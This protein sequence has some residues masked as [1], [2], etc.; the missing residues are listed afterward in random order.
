LW[1][2]TSDE[3]VCASYLRLTDKNLKYIVIDPNIATVVMGQG[4]SSLFHR[5]LVKTDTSGKRL[6]NGVMAQLAEMHMAGY[7]ELVHSSNL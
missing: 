4:N 5:F 3:D 6:N 2:W 1:K 7:V